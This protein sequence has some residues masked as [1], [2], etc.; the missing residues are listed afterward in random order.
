MDPLYS[1]M[2]NWQDYW[3]AP[4]NSFSMATNVTILIHWVVACALFDFIISGGTRVFVLIVGALCVAILECS[5]LLYTK[6][7][8]NV[9]EPFASL[10]N[11]EEQKQEQEQ[12]QKKPSLNNNKEDDVLLTSLTSSGEIAESEIMDELYSTPT[13]QNPF[14]NLLP[15]DDFRNKKAAPPAFNKKVK[16]NIKT[17]LKRQAQRLNPSIQNYRGLMYGD[18]VNEANMQTFD[19]IFYSMPCT[20]AADNATSFARFC[21]GDMIS[22][23]EDNASGK[24]ARWLT[25]ERYNYY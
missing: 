14:G 13:M 16:D 22:S 23:K 19:R 6:Y 15:T 11:T 10:N 3:D 21:F 4:R 18:R 17:Q 25:N 2:M 7:R 12:E 20:T 24:T 8:K 5:Y 9:F 1:A